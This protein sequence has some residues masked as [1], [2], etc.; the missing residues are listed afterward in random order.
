MGWMLADP[1]TTT[2]RTVLIATI[3]ALACAGKQA[4]A[5]SVS[6]PGSHARQAPIA[7][8]PTIFLHAPQ[9][10]A[11]HKAR[12]AADP[13]HPEPALA[14]LLDDARKALAEKPFSVTEKTALPPSGDRHDY[15]SLAPYAWPDPSKP[16][17]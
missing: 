11:S 8:G 7:A 1:S 15:L 12:Y 10:L 6:Q 16:S 3:F 13:Q 5:E 2:F 4:A 9:A 17:G 14:R